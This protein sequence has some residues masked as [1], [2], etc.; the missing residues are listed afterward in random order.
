[1]IFRLGKVQFWTKKQKDVKCDGSS[2][3]PTA[4]FPSEVKYMLDCKGWDAN[5]DGKV[6]KEDADIL[7]DRRKYDEPDYPNL[8]EQIKDL[9]SKGDEQITAGDFAVFLG[10][11]KKE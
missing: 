11:V 6:T 10:C 8:F 9:Y 7:G 2:S 1:M 5:N 3:F 4:D